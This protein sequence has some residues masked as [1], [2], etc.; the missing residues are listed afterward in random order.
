[1]ADGGQSL[2]I[3]SI[4]T[5]AVAGNAICKMM[6]LCRSCGRGLFDSDLHC[7]PL[8][9]V[10]A[11]LRCCDVGHTMRQ[12]G[13][14]SCIDAPGHRGQ[15]RQHE[16]FSVALV[17]ATSS[18]SCLPAQPPCRIYSEGTEYSCLFASCTS[19]RSHARLACDFY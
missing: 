3:R 6:Q 1:M 16:L 19:P 15:Y 13:T 10:N 14:A 11:M 17:A 7:V 8:R 5:L 18:P 12:I 4:A 2:L 9:S